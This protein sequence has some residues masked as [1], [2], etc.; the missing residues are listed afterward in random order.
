MRIAVVEPDGAGGLAHYAFQMSAALS[1]AGAEVT[2]V[3]SPHWELADLDR[4]FA[5]EQVIDLWPA[6]ESPVRPGPVAPVRRFWRRTRRIG[7]ALRYVWAWER[8]TRFLIRMRPD[9]VQFSVIQF[10]FQSFFLHRMRRAGLD[11]TQVCHEFELRESQFASVQSIDRWMAR[12]VFGAFQI[13]FFHG[14]ATADRFRRLFGEPSAEVRIIPHGNQALITEVADGGG[15][16]RNRYGIPPDRQVVLFFGGLRPSKGL[17]DLIDAFAIARRE[18]D[19]SLLIVGFP[20]TAFNPEDLI[21]RARRLGIAEDVDIDARYLPLKDVGP[22]IR[23]GAVVV[24]PYRSATASGVLQVAYAFGRPVIVTDVGD[25]PSSVEPGETGVVVPVG[26][27]EQFARAM[28]KMLSEPSDLARMGAA[29]RLA[30]TEQFSWGP[31]A[32]EVVDAYEGLS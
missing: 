9:I 25:L 16:L 15:D 2:L 13:M 6:V 29:A 20:T 12:S 26:D 22:L 10:P 4:S 1:S 5:V 19:A 18:I 27:V 8:L 31:I 7:R 23:T 3:T 24:L 14:E 21:A 32:S 28:V 11:L 17:P 30:A